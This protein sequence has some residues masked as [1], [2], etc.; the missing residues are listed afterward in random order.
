M[1]YAIK[2]ITRF[3][4]SVPVSE[5]VMEVRMQPRSD[6]GQR[7][8]S[9]QLATS[10]R[11]AVTSHRDYLGNTIHHFDV[12]GRHTS[13]TLTAE[14]LVEMQPAPEFP[15]ALAPEDWDAIDGL[16]REQDHWDMLAPSHF[17]RPCRE[18]RDLAHELGLR[19]DGDPLSTLR[20]LTA[21][22]YRG[23]DYAPDTTSVHSPIED[24][25]R[26]RRGVCQDFAHIMIALVRELGVPCRYVSGYLFHRHEDH[27]RSEEDASHA[28]V[29]AL[30]PGLGWVG[31]D[32]TN[33]LLAGARHIRTAVG[34]DYAD[35][36]PT[37]GVFKGNATSELEVA[38]RVAPTD[39]PQPDEVELAP[40][41]WQPPEPEAAELQA[42]QQQQ[43]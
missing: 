41:G 43:Q 9:F 16:T 27:D 30:L 7:C 28:W 38:V 5:S 21:R 36:P 40:L 11:A 15:A 3:R 23:F 33:N 17:A 34:R 20:E 42:Q 13:L 35:V 29:E 22:L 26:A 19:R 39:A 37:R 4:Y 24:A 2:H 6:A 32:P 14:S 1:F 12:P 25:L 18:L 8:R 10:P 31:F